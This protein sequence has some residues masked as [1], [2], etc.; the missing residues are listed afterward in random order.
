[1]EERI[2]IMQ[3]RQFGKTDMQITPLGLGTW[4]IGGKDWGSQDDQE[5]IHTIQ[6]AI[7][8]GINWIDTAPAYGLGHS[9]QIVGKAIKG[10]PDQPYIFT[11]CSLVWDDQGE[12]T[13]SLK[14][15]S[16]RREIEGSL[17]RLNVDVIDL[18][19]IHWPNP[20]EE[21]EEG[22]SILA[23]L[24]QEGKVRAIG[25][26]NFNVEQIQRIQ[27]IAPTA[28]LQSPYSL[29]RREIEKD[30]LPLCEQEHIAVIVYSPMESGLLSGTIT[31]ERIEKLPEED[32]RRHS[33]E[34][35]EPRLSHNQ[36]LVD[37]L[38]EI[39]YPHN[40][41]AGAVAIAWTL[42]NPAVTGAIVGARQPAQIEDLL[43]AAE[44]RLSESEM[45]QIKTFLKENP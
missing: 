41:P 44:F 2:D 14:A 42:H 20:E 12:I 40:V 22:W 18:Y 34:F 4:A 37:L 15:D 11:K 32:W 17:K 7:D 9:E 28:S 8:L 10:R 3:T 29:L 33:P 26:S 19:Q 36:K 21:I 27:K 25:V 30:I 13:S 16:I 6:R 24:Q 23:K 45:D 35:N 39:S 38:T 31:K 1:V 43:I 5:S